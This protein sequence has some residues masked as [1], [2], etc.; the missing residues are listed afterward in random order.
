MYRGRSFK[1]T[2]PLPLVLRL[3]ISAAILLSSTSI[4]SWPA[5]ATLPTLFIRN[6]PTLQQSVRQQ[7]KKFNF[8][9][10]APQMDIWSAAHVDHCSLNTNCLFVFLAL[11]PIVL[12]F[13]QP[14]S[15][16]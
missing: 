9:C 12:V 10:T 16:L 4:L 3:R 11:Q 7:I 15:R 6:I 8:T 5:Q 2:T 14:G 13:S 1:L